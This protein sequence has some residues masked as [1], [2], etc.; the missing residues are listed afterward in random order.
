MPD[1]GAR[2]RNTTSTWMLRGIGFMMMWL[3]LSAA[4]GWV[5]RLLN[6]IP[7]IGSLIETGIGIVAALLAAICSLLTIALTWFIY[8]PVLSLALLA[9]VALCIIAI[10]QRNRMSPKQVRRRGLPPPA[11]DVFK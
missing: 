11:P 3:G 10:R 1:V 6:I 8:R 4:L 9:V 2:E 5:G 7:W